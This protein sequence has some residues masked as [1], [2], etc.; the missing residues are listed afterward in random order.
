VHGAL[1][2]LFPK[3]VS[4]TD[5]NKEN[6]EKLGKLGYLSLHVMNAEEIELNRR[7]DTV[8]AGELI[9]HLA[10]PALVRALEALVRK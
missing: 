9:E 2:P 1:R 6:I 3:T 7:F 8:V 4:G 5:I 10:Y